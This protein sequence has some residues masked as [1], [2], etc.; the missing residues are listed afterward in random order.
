[1]QY[2]RTWLDISFR[3]LNNSSKLEGITTNWKQGT[4]SLQQLLKSSSKYKS[5][6]S[7][8]RHETQKFVR[9]DHRDNTTFQFDLQT[10]TTTNF[11]YTL[12]NAKMLRYRGK[13]A[14]WN[15]LF[16]SPS[17]RNGRTDEA[18]TLVSTLV[19]AASLQI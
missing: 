9:I 6:H 18:D 7:S 15:A 16:A 14:R 17:E 11:V 8:S 19:T 5:S 10:S 4:F 12:R 3:K 13:P 1:M 2:A